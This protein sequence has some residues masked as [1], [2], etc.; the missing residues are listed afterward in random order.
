MAMRKTGWVIAA[1][2]AVVAVGAWAANERSNGEESLPLKS[3]IGELL[4]APS[5]EDQKWRREQSRID[6]RAA[7]AEAR[8]ATAEALDVGD[9]DSFGRP[10]RW[11]GVM[12]SPTVFLNRD[13][14]TWND[15]WG[16]SI[17]SQ[18]DTRWG[19]VVGT[20]VDLGQIT[21]PGKSMKNTL[22]HWLTPNI[23]ANLQNTTEAPIDAYVSMTPYFTFE[24]EALNAPG[25]VDP[26][27]GEPLNGKVDIWSTSF[28]SGTSL[29]PGARFVLRAQSTRTCIGGYLTKQTLMA[30]YGLSELQVTEF[31]KKPTT[32]RMHM[33]L[34]TVGVVDGR[35]SVG[36]RW[37]GN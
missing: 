14:T 35:A 36:V 4:D 29:V 16:G 8:A 32:I 13:C 9:P 3:A 22:C 2:L 25:L 1:G 28:R 11:L 26:E 37:V 12:S 34:S 10:V 7:K 23:H 5:Q 19:R 27:E 21:L 15:P 20:H 17:C 24:N 6:A 30:Y 18:L 33:L 31:F